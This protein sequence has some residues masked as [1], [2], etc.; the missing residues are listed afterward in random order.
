MLKEKTRIT[1]QEYYQI[2]SSKYGADIAMLSQLRF[3]EIHRVVSDE[4]AN[5]KDE[6]S[7]LVPFNKL[8]SLFLD[9]LAQILRR[10]DSWNSIFIEDENVRHWISA[11]FL[12]EAK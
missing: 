2:V 3:A 4:I 8:V 12:N 9:R 11:W 7:E 6:R 5:A 1:E 10:D